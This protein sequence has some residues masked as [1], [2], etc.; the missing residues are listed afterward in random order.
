MWE[1][2]WDGLRTLSFGLSQFHGLGSWLVCEVAL[3]EG[4]ILPM[5]YKNVLRFHPVPLEKNVFF[6]F[7]ETVRLPHPVCLS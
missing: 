6:F 1:V 5:A 4:T 2:P 3:S 7:L